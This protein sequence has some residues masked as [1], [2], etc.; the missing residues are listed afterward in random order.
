MQA[1]ER[2]EQGLQQL[3]IELN[4]R[5]QQKLIDYLQL[6]LKWN[7]AYNLTAIRELDSMVIR[8]LLDSLSILPFIKS[9]PV[10]DV[11]TGP[12]LPGIPLAICLPDYHFV[13]LDSNGKKTR[14]LTQCKID[15]GLENIDIIHSRI[16]DY[17]PDKGFEIITCRAFAALN[18]I[19]D[20]TQHLLTSTTRVMAMKG[21][22]ELSELIDGYEQLA[23]HQLQVPWLNE[24]RQLLE[25]ARLN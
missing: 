16:E 8:H 1:E 25:I 9:S 20:R 15:L 6:M 23:Q 10:L 7:K 5:L 21:K 3:G 12:G 19:L 18:T 4:V 17:Q 11:G 14:F 2:L 13:L 24:D 22:D